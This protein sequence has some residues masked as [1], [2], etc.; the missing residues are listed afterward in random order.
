LS[1]AKRTKL[2]GKR[3][4]FS[5]KTANWIVNEGNGSYKDVI[6]A[7]KKV[8]A[9]HKALGKGCKREVIVWE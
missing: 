8:E 5:G 3:T 1:F 7:M 6:G 9:L 2:C 4:H